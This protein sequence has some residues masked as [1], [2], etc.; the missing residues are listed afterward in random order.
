MLC[1][2]LSY[3]YIL[4]Y[5]IGT[6][7]MCQLIYI[8]LNKNDLLRFPSY[9]SKILLSSP[10]GIFFFFFYCNRN[11]LIRISMIRTN[12]IHN[13]YLIILNNFIS[14]FYVYSSYTSVN[15]NKFIRKILKTAFPISI[16]ILIIKLILTI[17]HN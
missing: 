6:F 7:A 16:E 14:E 3:I 8:L 9:F 5:T 4:I 11:Y 1:K 10:Y 13:V 15:F 17:L 2:M 12:T